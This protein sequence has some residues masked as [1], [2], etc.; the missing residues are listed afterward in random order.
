MSVRADTDSISRR[1]SP[2]LIASILA[3]SWREE[4]PEPGFSAGEI[5][6]VLPLLTESGAGALAWWKIRHSPLADS[7]P[8]LTLRQT[9]HRQTLQHAIQEG[10]I[11]YVFGLL[12]S[13]GI[14]PI[15][16]K[17]WAAA[18]LYP[19]RGLRHPGDIDICVRPEQYAAAKAVE[20][21]PGR[22]G[23]AVVDLTHDEA[24]LLGGHSWDDLYA[25]S[26]L[27]ALNDSRIRVLGHED[28]LRFLCVHL[29]RHSAYRPLW[30][31]D[32][33]AAVETMSGSSDWRVALGGDSREGNWIACVLDLARRLLGARVDH[34]PE[35]VKK[36]R[37]PEWL[38]RE[39]LNQWKRPCTDQRRPHELMAVSLRRPSS[40]LP[41]LLARWP[42]PIRAAVRLYLPLDESPRLPRQLKFYLVQSTSFLKRPLRRERRP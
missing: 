3:G 13:H 41:A 11:E 24:Y 28:Q 6:G 36:L 42:D 31:C 12:R 22:G 15:L 37:A 16:L 27:V 7:A 33:A 30:L 5:E 21:E 18:G 8:A 9:Y 2:E 26:R 23:K 20:W 17:G 14:E 35:E 29:L 34:V 38:V 32:V 1:A 40:V 10:D 39:V 4:P 19:E 25:R